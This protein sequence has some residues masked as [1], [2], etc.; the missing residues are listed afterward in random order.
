MNNDIINKLLFCAD[1]ELEALSLKS[2]ELF[3]PV[4]NTMYLY[5]VSLKNVKHF[6]FSLDHTCIGLSFCETTVV[7]DQHKKIFN[8]VKFIS[9]NDHLLNKYVR[10]GV[11]INLQ[12]IFYVLKSQQV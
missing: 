4:F 8:N 6:K 7:I 10:V 2:M 5:Q 12:R 9:L 11:A 3:I 1:E